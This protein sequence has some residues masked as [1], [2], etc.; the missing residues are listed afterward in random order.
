MRKT[1]RERL[2]EREGMR[3]QERK[4]DRKSEGER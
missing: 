3:N 1:D 4:T 2:K